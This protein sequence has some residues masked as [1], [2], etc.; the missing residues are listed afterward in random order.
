MFVD[1]ECARKLA[2]TNVY[3]NTT[4]SAHVHVFDVLTD[5]DV[6]YNTNTPLDKIRVSWLRKNKCFGTFTCSYAAR[7][8]LTVLKWVRAQGCEWSEL[9]YTRAV[10]G[11]HLDVLQWAHEHGCPWNEW[12]T[13]RAAYQGKF[14][15]LRWLHAT[16]CPWDA[17]TCVE[18]VRGGHFHILKWLH[19]N[20]CAWDSRACSHAAR[21]GDLS[22]LNW[23]CT[24]GCP[25][26]KWCDFHDT[27]SFLPN[28]RALR[29]SLTFQLS[30]PLPTVFCVYAAACGS[31]SHIKLLHEHGCV[32][33]ELVCAVA[34]F[35]GHLSVL[36]YGQ[37]HG[38]PCGEYTRKEALRGGHVETIM[39]LHPS[40]FEIPEHV[41]RGDMCLKGDGCANHSFCETKGC[42]NNVFANIY[43]NAAADYRTFDSLIVPRFC[44]DHGSPRLEH[45]RRDA[46]FDPNLFR[47]V[48]YSCDDLT[49]IITRWGCL[50]HVGDD[51]MFNICEVPGCS[52][53][54]VKWEPGQDIFCHMHAKQVKSG[55]YAPM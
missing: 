55:R 44:M 11:G 29:F 6:L 51:F 47:R 14:Q 42:T 3:W 18:A 46:I 2:S 13:H 40:E 45:H 26:E 53:T 25:W 32:M 34:A 22:I 1:V 20:G 30:P 35:C 24:N 5:R 52:C 9:V 16:G 36:R 28:L 27:V 50:T 49:C 48:P 15:I 54:A 19:A 41:T 23:L 8:G 39:H 7:A 38:F 37:E 17:E 4:L 10:D 33:P 31:L 43:F 12:A 21:R